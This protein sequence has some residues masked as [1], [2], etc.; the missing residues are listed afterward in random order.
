MATSRIR[1]RWRWR[2]ATSIPRRSAIFASGDH[3]VAIG[4]RRRAT[5]RRPASDALAGRA[6]GNGHT[7]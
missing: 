4:W 2:C 1:L 7:D 5:G 3:V 6:Q